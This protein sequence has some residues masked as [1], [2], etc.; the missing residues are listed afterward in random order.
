ME[1]RNAPFDQIPI[2]YDQLLPHLIHN[3]L[4][5]PIYIE[6]LPPSFPPEYDLN[7]KCEYHDE[8]LGHHVEDCMKF[9]TQVQNLIDNKSLV[10]KEENPNIEC[11]YH[12]EAMGHVF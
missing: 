12:T 5:L 6:P 10:F 4:L 9:K 11:E 7:V 3:F 1:R 2:L 8:S